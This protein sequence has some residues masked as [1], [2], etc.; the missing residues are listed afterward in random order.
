[1]D[2]LE[3]DAWFE[4]AARREEAVTGEVLAGYGWGAH[5]GAVVANPKGYG[6]FALL[7]SMVLQA[8]RQLVAEWNLGVGMA[9]A[10]TKGQ[11]LIMARLHQPE[12]EGQETLM[13]LL[14]MRLSTPQGEW[15]MTE[16][17]HSQI[18]SVLSKVLTPKDWDDIASSAAKA[19]QM[20]ITLQF[21]FPQSA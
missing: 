4:A 10:E 14:A 7:R 11:E 2:L 1:M 16:A 15:Q 17:V 13:A 6:H 9:A 5:L 21:Q 18:R 12:S 8:W 20:H 19:V 3:D